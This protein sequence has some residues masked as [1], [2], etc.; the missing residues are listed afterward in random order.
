MV[1]KWLALIERTVSLDGLQPLNDLLLDLIKISNQLLVHL[2]FYLESEVHDLF[3]V[4]YQVLIALT[5]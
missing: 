2:Q 4:V 3:Y 5:L 1:D